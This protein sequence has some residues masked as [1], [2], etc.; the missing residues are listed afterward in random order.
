MHC[1]IVW[2]YGPCLP[3]KVFFSVR[4]VSLLVAAVINKQNQRQNWIVVFILRLKVCCVW[5]AK[6]ESEGI[7]SLRRSKNNSLRIF[8][9]S[10]LT[11]ITTKRFELLL[12]DTRLV[13]IFFFLGLFIAEALKSTFALSHC[14][15]AWNPDVIYWDCF[16]SVWK[17]NKSNFSE[18]KSTHSWL[19]FRSNWSHFKNKKCFFYY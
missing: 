19:V 6:I 4:V 2:V 7:H 13:V 3:K 5:F 10:V 1:F 12:R 16:N 17:A 8:F 9:S 14:C 15:S 11:R 18:I